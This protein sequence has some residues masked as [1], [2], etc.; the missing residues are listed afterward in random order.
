M[1]LA[2]VLPLLVSMTTLPSRIHHI[3]PTLDS[4]FAQTCMP[5]K[6]LLCL[7]KWSRRENA[8][9]DRPEWLASYPMLEVVEC[10]D[11]D[12]PGTKLL[13]A[14]DHLLSPVCL[15]VVDDDMRYR[16]DFLEHLYQHQ[17]GEPGTSFSYYT[18]RK[19]PVTIGQG[20]D[21][22]SFYGPNLAGI[23]SFAK[24]AIMSP[25]LRVQD[26]LWICAFL[27]HHGFQVKSLAHLLPDGEAVYEISHSVN[28]LRNLTGD[29][30]R[31]VVLT[32]GLNYMFEQGL[33]GRPA[34]I[35]ALMKRALRGPRD[36]LLSRIKS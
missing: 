31:R 10:A 29:L 7:P 13:G 5:D 18:Y 34:Q 32:D 35:M 36:A 1:A 24:K 11:D 9:Y 17:V 20:A 27:W 22:L 8:A 30:A 12:G 23:R 4:L 15:I 19:G 14:L 21:G 3:R 25:Q 6:V 2:R 33:L 16:P 26:D 28:Q